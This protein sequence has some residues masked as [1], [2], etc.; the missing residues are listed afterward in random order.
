[1]VLYKSLCRSPKTFHGVTFHYGETKAVHGYIHDS[2][3]IC[4]GTVRPTPKVTLKPE[5]AN[6][7]FAAPKTETKKVE[8]KVEKKAELKKDESKPAT[9]SAT[10]PAEK[11]EETKPTEPKK[12]ETKKDESKKS[13]TAGKDK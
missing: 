11:K 1:M 6:A 7:E 10:K 12:T 8:A 3:F 4:L 5:V 13:E 9:K 2:R